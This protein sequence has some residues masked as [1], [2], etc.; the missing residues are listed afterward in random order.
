MKKMNQLPQ[1]LLVEILIGVSENTMRKLAST[2]SKML[3]KI[4]ENENYIYNRKIKKK[5]D[6]SAYP[7]FEDSK[8]KYDELREWEE[9]DEYLDIID[10]FA[11]NNFFKASMK[12]IEENGYYGIDLNYALWMASGYGNLEFMKF[13]F[14]RGAFN[15]KDSI[16]EIIEKNPENL[17]EVLSLLLK[18]ASRLLKD[19]IEKTYEGKL[20][21]DI[22]SILRYA[23]KYN[24]VEMVSLLIEFANNNGIHIDTNYMISQSSFLGN[25][26]IT[27]M[28]Q[29]I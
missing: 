12:L 23:I 29:L 27:Q 21:I 1:T 11:E 2:S 18:E 19:G 3:N 16:D 13:L 7:N 8:E 6:I 24:Q 26:Q 10:E 4:L 17:L 25:T 14:S 15:I 22:N 5:Y 20:S 9:S 28:L